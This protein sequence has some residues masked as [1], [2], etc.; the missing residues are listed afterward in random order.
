MRKNLIAMSAAAALGT[1]G[2]VG[3][4]A[5]Q[6]AVNTGG[7]GH[8]LVF[9]YFTTNADNATSIAIVNT[10]SV[11]KAVKVRF[12]GA[13]NS[14]DV[15]DFTVLMSPGDV[16]TAA[17]TQ[18]SNGVSRLTTTDKTCTIPASVRTEGV[19]F[20]TARLDPAK[21]L[22]A[23]TR[24]GYIEV[25]NMANIPVNT[26]TTSLHTAIK[27][28]SG[29]APCTQTIIDRDLATVGGA[30]GALTAPTG[31]LAGDYIILQST[32]RAAWSG[33]ATALVAGVD[34]APARNVFWPQTDAPIATAAGLAGPAGQLTSDPLMG[35]DT[36]PANNMVTLRSYDLPD[37]ST[38]YDVTAADSGAQLA[39]LISALRTTQTSNQYETSPAI[40]GLT[41]IVFSQPARRYQVA[42]NYKATA[43][44]ATAVTGTVAAA[45]Y[46][47]AGGGFSANPLKTGVNANTIMSDR[48]LCLNNARLS[49]I[50]DREEQTTST[51]FVV[52]PG[53]PTQFLLCGEVA[54]TSINA[55]LSTA[56]ALNAQQTR[57]TV[58]VPYNTGWMTISTALYDSYVNGQYSTTRTGIPF[59]GAAFVR[60]SAA[61]Q[62]YG[63]TFGNKT[64]NN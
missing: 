58:T 7:T 41:D 40:G 28:V 53:D 62:N 37:L 33:S 1:F 15:L 29:V 42:V 2:L 52:S 13:R 10:D 57:Q 12:R 9:P 31:G 25:I 51:S 6:M 21:D 26:A 18:D 14:D 38:P 59:I 36:N 4:A 17:V 11:G 46:T 30:A 16:W 50:F 22:A 49:Q 45:V 60:A 63:F 44:S 55:P 61:N 32:N 48:T 64:R 34:G 27:H 8:Q 35:Q 54:V 23:Q 20:M 39:Q 56:S 47:A 5:A 19:S 43:T 3:G 24:E